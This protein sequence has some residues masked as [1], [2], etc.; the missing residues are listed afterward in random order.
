MERSH[1]E[2]RDAYKNIKLELDL[3]GRL[4]WIGDTFM[5]ALSLGTLLEAALTLLFIPSLIT[6]LWAPPWLSRAYIDG[7]T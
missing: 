2:M 3:N 4:Y 7:A 1:S 6:W 5:P